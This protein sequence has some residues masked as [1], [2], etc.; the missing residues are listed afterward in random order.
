M[1]KHETLPTSVSYV[2][3]CGLCLTHKV[4]TLKNDEQNMI[5][6]GLHESLTPA[7]LNVPR[8]RWC[9]C[10]CF[11]GNIREGTQWVHVHVF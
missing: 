9:S 8:S 5:V 6:K 2:L 11:V 10:L 7:P 4:L 3:F 1:L